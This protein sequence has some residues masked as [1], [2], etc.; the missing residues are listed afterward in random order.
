MISKGL[1]SRVQSLRFWGVCDLDFGVYEPRL[2][3]GLSD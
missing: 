3:E 2:Y 1:V